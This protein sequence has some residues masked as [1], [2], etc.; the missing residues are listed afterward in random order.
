MQ[1]VEFEAYIKITLII[2]ANDEN[3]DEKDID[4]NSLTNEDKKIVD[5]IFADAIKIYK[6]YGE[7]DISQTV[8]SNESKSRHYV[9]KNCEIKMN[10]GYATFNVSYDGDEEKILDTILYEFS[11]GYFSQIE[12]KINFTDKDM[13][14]KNYII[15]Y[16]IKY[17]EFD[18]PV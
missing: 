7:E 11:D 5:E 13:K 15:S 9:A 6:D 2:D 18:L 12:D 8:E 3:T 1:T 10:E 17:D 4:Y 14:N 16:E